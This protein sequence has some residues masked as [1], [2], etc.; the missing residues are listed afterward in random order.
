MSRVLALCVVGFMVVG[1][2]NAQLVAG[3]D[4]T[5]ATIYYV[6]LVS[7]VKTPLYTG[8][9][10]ASWGMAYDRSTNTLYWNNGGTLLKAPFS[11]AGLVPQVV[12]SMTFNGSSMNVTGMAFDAVNNKLLGYRSIT[13]PGFYEIS[14][15]N[16]VCTQVAL[17]PASTDFGGFE[18]DPDSGTFF[19]LNDGTGLSGRGLYL[20]KGMYGG[21]VSYE[22]ETA[23]PAGDTDIDGL[24][25]GGG[26]AYY[27]NDSGEEP[28]YR[29]DLAAHAYLA[30]MPSPFVGT[31][32]TFSGAT[33]IPEPA[34]ATLLVL[35]AAIR[36]T[37]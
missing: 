24:A 17:T 1:M 29:Y 6:D 15:S 36:R 3:N 19:G 27:V 16:A 12:G 13:A 2:A 26:L 7:G 11:L 23:Y 22:L 20:I 35:L 31:T 9:N 28:L 4:Q 30:S 21:A 34:A 5:G 10:A 32:G 14:T 25:I 18:F 37:R 33:F 8:T